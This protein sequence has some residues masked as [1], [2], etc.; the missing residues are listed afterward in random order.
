M[1]GLLIGGLY[2]TVPGVDVVSPG[3]V[4]WCSLDP[5]DYRQRRTPWVRA[6]VLHTTKGLHPQHI[7]PGRGPGNADKVVADFW[8]KDPKHSA[9]HIVVDT[10][11]TAAC[12]GDLARVTAY[13]ATVSNE[14]SVGIEM[15]QLADGGIYEA[16]LASTVSICRTICQALSIPFQVV[17]DRYAGRPLERLLKGGPDVIGIYGHRDNTHDRGRGDPGDAIITELV[18]GGAEPFEYAKRQD[19]STWMRRQL[20]L[21][22]R[23]GE[24]LDV[25][26]ICGPRTV[27]A[28]LRQGFRNG[29]EIDAA[30]A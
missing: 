9:A 2:F 19:I 13:H 1:G 24:H 3:E 30:G 4:P 25:D 17:A 27:A 11:G 26:G 28:M 7:I 5:G 23:R 10:D 6:I 16:T 21:V 18:H 14:W 20:W 12:L 8:R 22:Q 15:Y 29:R